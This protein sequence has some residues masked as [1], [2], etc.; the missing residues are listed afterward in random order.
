MPFKIWITQ[1]GYTVRIYGLRTA[2]SACTLF[3]GI[4]DSGTPSGGASLTTTGT[5][6]YTLTGVTNGTVIYV[7]TGQL[8]G[9]CAQV[10]TNSY[11][12]SYSCIVPKSF[13]IT[14]NTDISV[15]ADGATSC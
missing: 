2:A 3:Y 4:N 11:C 10:G 8:I 1:A 6:Y 14:A 5:L 7:N 12:S 13:T 15:K 9:I